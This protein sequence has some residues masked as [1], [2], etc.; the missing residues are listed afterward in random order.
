MESTDIIQPKIEPANYYASPTPVSPEPLPLA[1]GFEWCELDLKNDEQ[2]EELYQLLKWHYIADAEDNFFFLYSK[3]FIRWYLLQNNYR[4]DLHVGIRKSDDQ[5]LIGFIAAQPATYDY[6]KTDFRAVEVDFLCVDTRLRGHRFAPLLILEVCRRSNIHGIYQAVYTIGKKM[7]KHSEI[8]MARYFHRILNGHKAIEVG[9]VAKPETI[10]DEDFMRA[11]STPSTVGHPGIRPYKKSDAAA[12]VELVNSHDA[13]Y[14]LH[15]KWN[16]AKEFHTFFAPKTDIVQ[17]YVI[18]GEDGKIEAFFSFYMIPSGV[19]EDGDRSNLKATMNVG[20]IHTVVYDEKT[21]LST[22]D[23]IA[24]C[25][26]L[27]KEA[28]CDILNA[29][30]IKDWAPYLQF[31]NFWPGDGS[32]YYYLFGM[33]QEACEAHEVAVNIV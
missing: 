12:C 17:S 2:L 28:G 15:R 33:E 25:I 13:K 9:F 10:E 29:L 27:A 26:I 8:T 21:D 14:K 19:S 18:E 22:G 32:L 24:D 3:E 20:Y 11:F 5:S 7:P 1:P 4:A 31:L 6:K 30:A 16:G 23:L